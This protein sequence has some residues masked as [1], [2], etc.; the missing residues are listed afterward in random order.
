MF[1][2]ITLLSHVV[3]GARGSGLALT[4]LLL[5][6]KRSLQ[7]DSPLGSRSIPWASRETCTHSWGAA[8]ILSSPTGRQQAIPEPAWHLAPTPTNSPNQGGG[9]SRQSLH[10]PRHVEEARCS[11]LRSCGL[12]SASVITGERAGA[13]VQ[14][15]PHRDYWGLDRKLRLSLV[16]LPREQHCEQAG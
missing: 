9:R 11:F 4:L 2:S 7:G 16:R 8:T 3:S 12:V 1:L 14:T 15:P 10:F 6:S 5:P 13:C